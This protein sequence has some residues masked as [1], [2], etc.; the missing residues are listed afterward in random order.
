MGQPDSR[1]GSPISEGD[2]L[3][4]PLPGG[5]G[6][7]Q[8]VLSAEGAGLGTQRSGSSSNDDMNGADLTR[9]EWRDCDENGINDAFEIALDRTK[10]MNENGILDIC[11]DMYAGYCFCDGSAGAPC[12]NVDSTAGCANSTGSGALISAV[13]T[14]SVWEDDL[15]IQASGMPLNQFGMFFLG[16]T[17]ASAP[18]KDGIRCVGGGGGV[19]LIRLK[20]Q[21]VDGNGSFKRGPG[22]IQ[23]INQK[24]PGTIIVGRTI[25]VQ[26]W[27]RDGGGSPC[28]T[29]SNLTNGL[30]VLFTL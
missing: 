19:G 8:I 10:D 24:V 2:I 29:F 25:Y 23:V 18:I 27:Y 22:L 21:A 17:P 26:A 4:P 28:G 9:P 30:Q 15:I 6:N 14:T 5:N 16:G 20:A 11:E 7:P 3:G 12:G 1:F 13:G